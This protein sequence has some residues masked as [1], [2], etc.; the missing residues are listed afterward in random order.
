MKFLVQLVVS[1][2]AVIITSFIL[3]GVEIDKAL[4]GVI[5]AAV[6]A[7]LNAIV[8]PILIILTI[9]ITLIT[10]GLFLLIINAGIILLASKIVPGFHVSGFWTALLFSIILSIVTS[11]FNRLSRKEENDR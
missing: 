8:K 11:F 6:L 7:L 5:V 10:M 9:P 1:A 4:T 2:L 3:P